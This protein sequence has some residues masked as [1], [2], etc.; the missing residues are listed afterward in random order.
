MH[1]SNIDLVNELKKYGYLKTEKVT[2][3][4]LKHKREEFVMEGNIE[5]IYNNSPFYLKE[6]RNIVQPLIAAFMIELMELKAGDKVLEIGTSTGWQTAIISDLI[7]HEGGLAQDEDGRYGMVSVEEDKELFDFAQ[8]KIK[9][10]GNFEKKITNIING[11]FAKGFDDESP[12]DKI[13]VWFSCSDISKHWEDQL[14]IGGK[15]VLAMD[16]KIVLIN[17]KGKNE[18]EKRQ[19]FGYKLDNLVVDN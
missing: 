9:S 10:L 17:K 3:A 12:Y 4:F 5:K 2:N 15:M 13:I 18:Y 7:E 11:D 6:K 16:K 1:Q 19:Y 14:S 8:N